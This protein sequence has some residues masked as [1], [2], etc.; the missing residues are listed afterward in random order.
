VPGCKANNVDIV[1]TLWSNLKKTPEM[2]VGQIG[3]HRQKEVRDMLLVIVVL[4]AN[5]V[6]FMFHF[7]VFFIVLSFSTL[8][9]LIVQHGGY[10]VC[11]KSYSIWFQKFDLTHSNSGKLDS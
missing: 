6:K 11:K 7:T 1:Y 2:D 10:L 5:G 8:K 4:H 9:L 3:F